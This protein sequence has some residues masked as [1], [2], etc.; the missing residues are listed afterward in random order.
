MYILF[1]VHPSFRESH[2]SQKKNDPKDVYDLI[3]GIC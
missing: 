1:L 2:G 3:P